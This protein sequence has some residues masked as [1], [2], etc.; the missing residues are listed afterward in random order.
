MKTKQL[1]QKLTA[2][3]M[4]SIVDNTFSIINGQ[5]HITDL[6]SFI[7]I[8]EHD[9]S[10]FQD[11]VYNLLGLSTEDDFLDFPVF[12]DSVT[13]PFIGQFIGK[14]ED[15]IIL[16]EFIKFVGKD[17]PR[18]AMTGIHFHNMGYIEA[19]DGH[20]LKRVKH[21]PHE[22]RF[23]IS[24]NAAKKIIVLCEFYKNTDFALSF[25]GKNIMIQTN[26]F[27]FVT[28]CIDDKFPDC[29]SVVPPMCNVEIDLNIDW[30]LLKEMS[31]NAKKTH[32]KVGVTFDIN[33]NCVKYFTIDN[34]NNAV[35]YIYI[36]DITMR[37]VRHSYD[38]ENAKLCMPFYSQQIEGIKFLAE[39]LLPFEG[40]STIQLIDNTRPA[41]FC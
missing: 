3:S 38:K 11:G 13:S 22:H 26:K 20:V 40:C 41:C 10:I 23:I 16:K 18:P 2:K 9:L 28:S 39:Y 19:T 27:S 21:E 6:V 32:H 5:I 24:T 33:N 25:D 15:L 34:Y 37:E 35:N 8:Y 12:N 36:S 7:R 1:I 17:S 29:E 14:T 30:K 4:L 31:K